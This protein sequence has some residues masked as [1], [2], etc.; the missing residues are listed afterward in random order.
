MQIE[1]LK[2]FVEVAEKGS[3]NLA[4]EGLHIS[5]QALSQSMR[6]LEKEMGVA[7]LDRSHKGIALTEK[8]QA[9]F[10]A[11]IDI[12]DRWEQLLTKLNEDMSFKI[13]RVSIAR[14]LEDYYYTLLLKNI[15]KR[16]LHMR[17]DVQNLLTE[18]AAEALEKGEIDL[19]VVCFF[20]SEIEEFLLRHPMLEFT[21]KTYINQNLLVSR[22]SELAKNVVLDIRELKNLRFIVEKNGEMETETFQRLL[23]LNPTLD[24]IGVNSFYAKQ[25]MVAENLG[26]TMNI[27]DGPIL[28]QYR[29]DLIEIPLRDCEPMISGILIW[30]ETPKEKLLREIINQW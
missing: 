28:N 18:E 20:E 13:L 25:R 30:R 23:D 12:V 2:Y 11:A 5:Q 29:N 1:K 22:N 19:S 16:H 15:E 8:G 24:V 6:N 9:F 14:L 27:K 26:V 3:I 4:C 7:L 17:L 21:A 10:E